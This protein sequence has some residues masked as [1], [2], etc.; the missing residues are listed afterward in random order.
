M[1]SFFRHLY[2]YGSHVFWA[3][4]ILMSVIALILRFAVMPNIDSYKGRIEAAV[5]R[6]AN[7]PVT[8]ADIK[9][10]WKHINPRFSL[11]GVA[12][13]P[14]GQ[15]PALKVQ[16]VDV[17]LSWLSLPLLEP[18]L[19]RLDVFQPDL[20]VRRDAA[21]QLYVA[22]IPIKRDG[23]DSP[24]P[25]WLLRQ[26]TL[27]LSQGRL[28][29]LDE[30]RGAPP[31]VLQDVN[32][33][34][35]NRFSRHRFGLTARPPAEAGK[36]V[37]FRGE[38]KGKSVHAPADW[39]GRL[40]LASAGVSAA[41]LNTWSPWAQSAVRSS[42]GDL[43]AWADIEEGKISRLLGDVGL[44]NVAVSLAED[45]PDITFRNIA[46]R[47]DWRSTANSQT[48]QV[49]NLSFVTSDGR[50]GEPADVKVTQSKQGNETSTRVEADRVRLETLTAL[51]GSLPLPKQA[52]DW[53]AR[54]NPRGF[55][56]HVAF[57]WL[58]KQRFKA[59]AKFHDGGMNPTGSIPG[60]DGLSGEFEASEQGGRAS[61]S[62][63]GLQFVYE[64]VFRQPLGLTRL[65]ADLNWQREAQGGYR[66]ELTRCELANADLDGEASG[67]ITLM[68][69]QAPV[70]DLTAHLSRGSGTVVWRYL[71]NVIGQNTYDWVKRSILAGDS[72]DTRLV[73]R[74]PLDRFPFIGGGGE[75]QVDVAMRNA[76]LE[77]APGW[78]RI[79]G[80]QGLLT[81]KN[82]AMIIK[83]DSGDILGVKLDQ[84]EG[85]VPDL[86]LRGNQVL[87][88][89]GRAKGTTRNFLEF[90]RQS[91]VNDHTGRFTETL[92][93][94]GEAELAL[95]LDMPLHHLDS[96]KVAGRVA[97]SNNRITLGDTLPTL[98]QVTGSLA[99]TE[100]TLKGD[101]ISAQLLGQ[102]ITLSLNGESGGQVRSRLH[103]AL[104]AATLA[105]WL[106]PALT[107]RIA[108]AA[109]VR[110]EAILAKRALTLEV[111]SDLAGLAIDLP[112]P[113]G[114]AAS[115]S[116][117]TTLSWSQH[118]GRAALLNFRYGQQLAGALSLPDKGDMR[119]GLMLGGQQAILPEQ[120]GLT[121]QGGL[122]QFDLDAWRAL[123][124]KSAGGAGD[125]AVPI[126]DIRLSFSE[127]KAF[128]RKLKDIH[129]QANQ[130]K[131]TWH[132][133]LSGP[134][135]MGEVEYGP[136]ADQPGSRFLGRFS[137]L[138]I[139][140][141]DA[142]EK[143][144]PSGPIEY[145]ELPAEVDL[146]AKSFSFKEREL[147]ELALSFRVEK[148]GLRVD[149]LKLTNPDSQLKG[150]GWISASPLR[151]TELDLHLVSPNL[152]H[153]VRRLGH[154][155]AVKGGDMTV[156]GRITWLG[157]PEDFSN[158]S[159]GG[160][161]SVKIKDGR[162]TQLD[163][164][165]A[166]LLGIL[167]LQ[168][169][170]RR[171]TLDFRDIFSEGYSFDDIS[172]DI[173][174]DRGIGY[175]PGLKIK[176]PAAKIQMNGK[177]DLDRENQELRVNIQPRL[178]E[179]LAV[180]AAILG[181][182]VAGVG[183]LVASKI[184]QDPLAKAASF[185]Y[186][187]TGNWDDPIVKKL[188]RPPADKTEMTP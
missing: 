134:N 17:T 91:P 47:L 53:I 171:I 31:L 97:L 77:Y 157:R 181:G 166:K 2:H 83:A 159:L 92:S 63:Q 165:A 11:L 59:Q 158:K 70:I 45:L 37:D 122:R 147:G 175:L 66:G 115:Q 34:L 28:T 73:L 38:L 49:R 104:S 140:K 154:P 179:G 112:A 9:A 90:V 30:Q 162:F 79:T 141:E 105:Q 87:T 26:P 182:P 117:P 145:G 129:V 13:T 33:L 48:Y 170:P 163:P 24:I 135:M 98:T 144:A 172:G 52:H 1:K 150:G 167:S 32:L 176:G 119:I 110:A 42:V 51:S 84:V 130:K 94:D 183:A 142:A 82:E 180:G 151:N 18:H 95:Q 39:N 174:I 60:F 132:F 25:D 101:N 164:G 8:I 50:R 136:R 125:P 54:L 118:D 27:T 107:K 3:A 43:R 75:F 153:L 106:P 99:F 74:G 139:P 103:G 146:S 4:I 102:P 184:L 100:K 133:N 15:A 155:E 12:L 143:T 108:G 93:A 40:Y 152:G 68:P 19:T 58:G 88:M 16:R 116:T 23:P 161:L 57:D 123:D 137:K 96:S 156:D 62:S 7:I 121:V 169:L 131:D 76:V 178:D 6:A 46:G 67:K 72:P 85:R 127:A 65:Q 148:N 185:E 61:L 20:N 41:G 128:G 186:L 14:P 55:L 21:G 120:T 124:F 5:S 187:V 114:K 138:A 80:I 35:K 149:T 173:Y 113:A 109:E 89:T 44:S 78:P 56:D 36:R 160:K 81:F 29:W 64:P 111:Q 69:D 86:H 10:D 126:R 168:A 22:G 71:P 188:P 177:V